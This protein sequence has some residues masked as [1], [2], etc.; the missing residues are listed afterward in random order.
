MTRSGRIPLSVLIFLL[1]IFWIKVSAVSG[2]CFSNSVDYSIVG[3]DN[4]KSNASEEINQ[5]N[6]SLLGFLSKRD[7]QQSKLL[8]ERI[9]GKIGKSYP[10]SKIISDSYYSVGVY[11][12]LINNPVEAIYFLKK[13]IEI[14]EANNYKNERYAKALL[15]LGLAY[16]ET[17]DF[18]N[19]E[20][21]TLRS[22]DEWKKISGDSDP[23]LI[24]AY[25]SLIT[26]YIELQ[27]YEKAIGYS[28][29]AIAILNNNSDVVPPVNSFNLYN[30]LGVCYVRLADFSKAR[31]YLDKSESIYI[32]NGLNL[33][34]D[35]INLMNSMA[36]TYMNLSLPDKANDY[37]ERGIALAQSTNSS[38]AYNLINSYAIFLGNSGKITKG[39]NLLLD[40]L[41]MATPKAGEGLHS[42]FEVMSY[43]ADYLREYKHENERSIA[44][45][46]KCIDYMNNNNQDHLFK[47]SVSIGYA[48]SLTEAGYSEKALGV[49]QSLIANDKETLQRQQVFDNPVV[50][51]VKV[52]RS[53][54]RVFGT[55]YRI[56]WD[57]YL[58]THDDK[59]LEAA[60]N[61]AEFIVSLIEK[62]RINIS[63]EDSRFILGEKYRDA[64]LNA[65]RDFNLLY[66]KS[67]DKVYLE[68]AFTYSE[69]S[70]AAG[71]LTSSRELRASQF[72]IPS[73]ISFVEQRLQREINLLNVRIAEGQAVDNPDTSM[74]ADWKETLIGTVRSKD[75]LIRVVEKQYPDYYSNK[76]NT[77]VAKLGD[78]PSI[79]GRNGNY[80]NYITSDTLLYIFVANRKH[81]KLLSIKI[82]TSFYSD[83]NKFRKLLSIPPVENARTAF[84]N[85]QTVGLKLYNILI[86]PVLPYLISDELI[87]SPD[88]LLAYIPFETLP[89]SPTSLSSGNSIFY[90]D[91]NY[92][93]QDY[94]ISYT[95]SAT[96]MAESVKRSYSYRNRLVAF[97]PNYPEP[98]D[99]QKVLM[100]R[101]SDGGLLQDLPYARQEAAFVSELTGGKLYENGQA[102]ESNYKAE[103][104]KFDIIHLA[105]H[106]LINIKDPMRSTLIFSHEKDTINDGY[107]KT[108]EVY[109]IPL[110]AK[111][112][113]LSSCNTG[114]GMMD[115]GEGIL[116]LARG[117]IYS[118]GQSVVMSMWE[119][120][121]KSGT[122]I[123]KLFY[124]NLKLGNSKSNALRKARIT[125]LKKTDQLRSHPYFWST[126]VI[127]GNNEPLYFSRL[128]IIAGSSLLIILMGVLAFHLLKRK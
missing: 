42:Y 7:F 38:L 93:M 114:T 50:D 51:S 30:N 107:L 68:K 112:V 111:M 82:D 35:Y 75:S 5:M 115:S 80:L 23:V 18:K 122:D 125:Y 17:G 92:L 8:V 109:G 72:H 41:N 74:I 52:D 47:S 94:D 91:I 66:S 1:F 56:L 9:I 55:K 101:Q 126:L 90:R 59:Y 76:Y 85:Y 86:V 37:Y 49:I 13:S 28:I 116:S 124:K 78:I 27:D 128:Y 99:I 54:L 60:S 12:S 10:E 62:V 87:I 24:S 48:L 120:E 34:N 108:Y 19:L 44:C 3:Y 31:I 103:S 89:T 95:Y 97:A 36:I 4:L 64:Y 29:I 110:K 6:L 119:I 33:N 46:E 105:M 70:K 102:S 118:G 40:A 53:T 98:I 117:F 65:I 22:L 58:N 61:T 26:A 127:Y 45:F 16:N 88:N 71:L 113:V 96:F 67:S 81:Q 83:I 39:E 106:T 73:N 104:G 11:Y 20:N 121:D 84:G 77:L 79:V 25:L 21:Y 69:K 14:S 2:T 43:Y 15:N 100:S 63:E 123:V 32:S 57:I